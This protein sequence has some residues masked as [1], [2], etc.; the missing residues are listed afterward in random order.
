MTNLTEDGKRRI[1]EKNSVAMKLLW[2]DPVYR[3][4]AI[5][6]RKEKI[7]NLNN[8]YGKKHT[9]A[10][11]Q[12]N[13]E[14]HL[15]KRLSKEHKRILLENITGERSKN[16]KGEQVSYSGSHHWV[17]KWRGSPTK[18]EHCGRDGLTSRKI[19]WANKSHKY[20]RDLNDW[21]RLCVPC[22]WVYDEAYRRN[23]N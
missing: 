23:S 15:G 20:L 14:A 4:K 2:Q 1:G 5:A 7:G 12:K 9:E 13:R 17:K 11:N 19:Q 3:A 21:I 16:W 10:T 6:K 18:C 8:F 22:H